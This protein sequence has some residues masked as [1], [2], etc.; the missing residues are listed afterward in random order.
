MFEDKG[1]EADEA[2]DHADRQEGE[3][4]SHDTKGDERTAGG[5]DH[6]LKDDAVVREARL[7]GAGD[8]E[9]GEDKP[10]GESRREHPGLGERQPGDAEA[11]DQHASKDF[12]E[13]IRPIAHGLPEGEERGAEGD[14]L[15]VR[16]ADD[17]EDE[18]EP[19]GRTHH[20]EQASGVIFEG[21]TCRLE[22]IQDDRDGAGEERDS[23]EPGELAGAVQAGLL[24]RVQAGAKGQSEQ[25]GNTD[26]HDP[27]PR[28]KV[29]PTL[30]D[31]CEDTDRND[32][33]TQVQEG[34]DGA[35]PFGSGCRAGGAV[36]LKR[37]N[38][39]GGGVV[40]HARFEP[41][42]QVFFHVGHAHT[43]AGASSWNKDKR[44]HPGRLEG[45]GSPRR[46]QPGREQPGL[47]WTRRHHDDSEWPPSPQHLSPEPPVSRPLEDVRILDLTWVL[48]GP[49][50]SM[51]L[52]DLGA[53]VIKVERPP[54]GDISRTTGPYQN[55]WSGYFFSIN[56]GK[57][58]VAIDLRSA[59]GKE[60]FLRLVEHADVV[61]ENFT[62]GTLQ[63]LGI[64]YETLAARNPRIVLASISGFGQSGPYSQ[65]PALDIVVQAMGGVMSITGEPG[66]NP[67]RPGA[68]YGDLA[69]GMFAV[70]GVLS[71]L[72]ERERSGQGQAVDISM[73]DTQVTV[74]ENA[75]MR[76]FV[77]GEVPGPLG[78]RHPSATPFQAFPTA[79]GHI[80]IALGFGEE[81]QWSLLCAILG[82]PEVIDDE[83]FETGPK[84][85]RNH[86]EL[87]P[88]LAR[89]FQQRTTAEWYE[90][91]LAAGIPCGPVNTVAEV[92]R[93]EHIRE[94][95]M[96]QEVTHPV[97]GTIP[98]A[99]SPV[100]MSRS[101]AGIKG[102]PPSLGEDTADVFGDLLGLTPAEVEAL[103]IRGIVATRGGP[104]ISTII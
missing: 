6:Q 18:G 73:L 67:V 35:G 75:I 19:R 50:A 17:P 78:T 10:A 54:F 79:D 46:R 84:R 96:I 95:G 16:G 97:A 4:G 76:Y 77:T 74:M 81:N 32:D 90:D 30:F 14:D 1:H 65:R 86:A 104:D 61:M 40:D 62:P 83:R 11:E 51:I 48:A 52:C 13:F 28:I 102:P 70:I 5:E 2:G 63:R 37:A 26:G 56:R 55:G 64:G 88:V 24:A 59:E 71:A 43:V 72:H 91:L 89:A 101:E 94:R 58:S 7:I 82:V 44:A 36:A 57:R 34:F 22:F 9:R 80:V 60:L 41:P 29:G 68:S 27:G 100:K 103:A 12:I 15:G 85:T 49:F 92:V 99:N 93:D 31:E 3:R 69:A 23:D 45:A 87:E 8:A 25:G 20:R 53:E 66:G 39:L 38:P 21:E 33:H 42:F 98:I 47:S